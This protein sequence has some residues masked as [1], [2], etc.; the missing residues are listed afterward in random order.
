MAVEL[1][2]AATQDSSAFA[3]AAQGLEAD[4]AV[5]SVV[6][7]SNVIVDNTDPQNPIVSASAL[8][9]YIG[10]PSVAPVLS[11]VSGGT[12]AAATYY[13]K[14]TYE[15]STGET[16]PSPESNLAV[17]L[18]NLLVVDSPSSA[19]NATGYNVYVST[20]TGTETKQNSTPI[21]IGTNWTEP[22]SG[23]ISGSALPSSN[24]TGT[25]GGTVSSVSVAAANGFLASVATP[26]TTP[27]ITIKTGVTGIL[28]GNGTGV[29]AAVAGN[30]PEFT[31]T[32]NG[33][34]PPSGGGAANFLR[35]DATWNVPP[36]NFVSDYN[37]VFITASA[38]TAWTT[39]LVNANAKLAFLSFLAN[40][41]GTLAV[42]EVLELNFRETGT[43]NTI[44]GIYTEAQQ[45]V[46]GVS[47]VGNAIVPCNASGNIDYEIILTSGSPTIDIVVYLIGYL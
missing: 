18:D 17:A 36:I 27:D 28:Y 34:V 40:I 23:L 21:S 45:T 44:L 29:S 25:V 41:S 14:I 12:L 31:T 3:T 38:V 37:N 33:A 43:T 35:A 16:L 5:K 4:A 19:T 2:T 15:N 47:S 7:G 46:T 20:T 8:T 24:T 32:E 22:T 39:I 11:S 1:G 6:A 42:G 13:V 30:F 9:G 26:T 10:N